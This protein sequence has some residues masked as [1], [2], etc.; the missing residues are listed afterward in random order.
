[1]LPDAVFTDWE[2]FRGDL[3]RAIARPPAAPHVP[4]MM[5]ERYGDTPLVKKLGIKPGMKVALIDAPDEFERTLGDLPDNVTLEERLTSG[6]D[7][8]IWFVRSGRDLEA[9]IGRLGS[10]TP[11]GGIW[12]AYPKKASGLA[13]DLTQQMVRE[14]GLA[15]GLVDFKVCAVD[16]TWTGLKFA[17]RK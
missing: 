17:R 12:I 7:L 16:A 1:V 9:R 8:A 5:M 14:T 13:T 3:K 4:K 10:A 6:S 2:R 15:H 11:R